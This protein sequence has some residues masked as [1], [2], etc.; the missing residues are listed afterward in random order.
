MGVI[1]PQSL[2]TISAACETENELL[3]CKDEGSSFTIGTVS[4]LF[5]LL[6]AR[7]CK[8][9]DCWLHWLTRRLTS[10]YAIREEAAWMGNQ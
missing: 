10:V 4:Q 5:C 3:F 2:A 8:M 6:T 9:I 7:D 1:D